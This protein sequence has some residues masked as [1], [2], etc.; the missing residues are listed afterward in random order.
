VERVVAYSDW[1]RKA[2]GAR[3]R[4]LRHVPVHLQA[5]AAKSFVASWNERIA[6]IAS[7]GDALIKAR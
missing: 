4:A 1:L 2:V 3:R 7:K 6:G 5:D